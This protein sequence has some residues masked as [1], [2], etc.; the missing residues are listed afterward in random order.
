MAVSKEIKFHYFRVIFND[1]NGRRRYD[2]REWINIV[3][4]KELIERI[5]SIKG[6][7]SRLE[8]IMVM[9]RNTR[10]VHL[11]FVKMSNTFIPSKAFEN[12][13]IEPIDLDDDEYIATDVNALFNVDNQVL[14]IQNNRGSLSPD[15]IK[16]YI[17]ITGMIYNCFNDGEFVTL[18]PLF[19]DYELS[20]VQRKRYRTLE[21]QFDNTQDY[22]D[23]QD[24]IDSFLHRKLREVGGKVGYVKFGM[25]HTSRKE[26]FYEEQTEKLLEIIKNSPYVKGANI[27]YVDDID[28]HKYDLFEHNIMMDKFVFTL[29]ERKSLRCDVAANVM[30]DLFE[31]RL[32]TIN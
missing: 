21:I 6:Y 30:L 7:P 27:T 16:D 26:G 15:R 14:M 31:N 17:N 25:G 22:D 13:E 18:E 10:F 12:Q 2:L 32:P 20:Q 9:N 4:D 24:T 11:Q 1:G 5:K 29:Q 19:E 8:R 3:G 23:N 28:V